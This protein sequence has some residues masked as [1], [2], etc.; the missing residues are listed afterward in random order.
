MEHN[1][2][3]KTC[4]WNLVVKNCQHRVYAKSYVQKAMCERRGPRLLSLA[5]SKEKEERIVLLYMHCHYMSSFQG[6]NI[7]FVIKMLKINKQK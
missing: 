4:A 3:K 1:S 2:G 7:T 6:E 5:P